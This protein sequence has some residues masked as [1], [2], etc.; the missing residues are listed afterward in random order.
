MID[1]PRE[2][3]GGEP[4][5]LGRLRAKRLMEDNSEHHQYPPDSENDFERILS[6]FQNRREVFDSEEP[7]SLPAVK[8]EPSLPQAPASAAAREA[9]KS[10]TPPS[11]YGGSVERM[12]SRYAHDDWT[13]ADTVVYRM[14]A[15]F[16]TSNK[17]EP[18][19]FSAMHYNCGFADLRKKLATA[20]L[21]EMRDIFQHIGGGLIGDQLLIGQ[22]VMSHVGVAV[23]T[24]KL[25]DLDKAAALKSKSEDSLLKTM[26]FMERLRSPPG[27]TITAGQV[28]VGAVQQVMN[29]SAP[30]A[31][32]RIDGNCVGRPA[33]VDLSHA[34][35]ASKEEIE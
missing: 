24:G 19:V 26:A 31:Q 32:E 28:N 16:S 1:E 30:P 18:N 21:P 27:L 22:L 2:D 9:D 35:P 5:W 10:K 4:A 23:S 25:A 13:Q 12:M 6:D 3:S 33:G 14:E 20:S 11:I 17:G 15:H 29:N 8:P 34:L 7:G